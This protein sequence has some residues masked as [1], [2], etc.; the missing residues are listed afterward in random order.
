MN[1]IDTPISQQEIDHLAAFLA[2]D[3]D[4]KAFD[5]D[6]LRGFLWAVAGSPVSLELDEWL[7]VIFNADP[8]EQA[9]SNY[10]PFNSD[11]QKD[12][13]LNIIFRLRYQ[14]IEQIIDEK[15]AWPTEYCIKGDGKENYNFRQWCSG[16]IYGYVW[17]EEIWDDC[18]QQ[19]ASDFAQDEQEQALFKQ[20]FKL[21][22][23]ALGYFSADANDR[24][25]MLD[26]FA[27]SEGVTFEHEKMPT[28]EVIK[29]QLLAYGTLGY[30]MRQ[31]VE[32]TQQPI[33]VEKIGRNDPCPC[34]S[35]K[36]YKKCCGV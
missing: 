16:F 31:M 23:F 13:C 21:L 24:K 27:D 22:V 28:E 14:A 6:E 12:T 9:P 15:F 2:Q 36:K 10:N 35:G 4:Y 1:K 32:Q 34:G 11:E 19:V 3:F 25:I 20:Q 30:Q 17:L 33:R 5:I 8:N 29:E 7:S 18:L 26:K